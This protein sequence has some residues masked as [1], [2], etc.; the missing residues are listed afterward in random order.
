[1]SKVEEKTC[2]DKTKQNTLK[3]WEV[4]KMPVEYP[5][6][7]AAGKGWSDPCNCFCG[8]LCCGP[9]SALLI[10]TAPLF[11]CCGEVED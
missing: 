7:E 5:T 3:W 1:M 8:T 6:S 9:K 4:F 11:C 2:L 10:L